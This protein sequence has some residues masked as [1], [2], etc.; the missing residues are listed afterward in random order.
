MSFLELWQAPGYIIELLREWPFETRVC[1]VKS[2]LLSSY[3]RHLSNLS[4]AWQDN[5]DASG[6]EAEGQV[7]L[8]IWHCFIGIPINFHKESGIVRF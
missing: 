2:E 4:Y 5:T 3:D 8:I 1:S 7:T 6:G